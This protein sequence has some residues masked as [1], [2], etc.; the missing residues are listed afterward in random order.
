MD[1]R[2]QAGRA[3]S[4]R[5][6]PALLHRDERCI[7]FGVRRFRLSPGSQ[8]EILETAASAFLTGYNT[9]IRRSAADLA[10][11]LSELGEAQRGHA[12]EGAGMGATVL[13]LLTVGRGRRL[14][15]LLEGP[16]RGHPHL[17]L[18]GAGRGYASLRRRPSRLGRLGRSLPGGH[19]THPALR[20]LAWDGYGCHRGFFRSD[21]TIGGQRLP[22]RLSAEQRALFDQ[23]VGR[24]IW[25]HEC[26]DPDG[27]A[28]RIA[29][30]TPGRRGDLWSG[31]ALAATY[32]GGADVA[33]LGRLASLSGEHRADVAH[34]SALAC[35]ARAHAGLIPAHTAAAAHALTGALAEEA[36][37][38]VATALGRL[39]PAAASPGGYRLWRQEV[40]DLWTGYR[41]H[42]EDQAAELP[43]GASA[44]AGSSTW[45]AG[46]GF[47]AYVPA[48]PGAP[49]QA[50]REPV[51]VPGASAEAAQRRVSV[52]GAPVQAAHQRA[53]VPG[54]PAE[55]ARERVSM[56]GAPAEAARERVSM[57]GAPAEAAHQPVPV[58]GTAHRE[59]HRR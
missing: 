4:G 13:D 19:I 42:G 59:E 24:S 23:G 39:G 50:S 45:D 18:A 30:F 52:P 28:L 25:F 5:G 1:V 17:V 57:P 2:V 7:D 27:V 31:A 20:W 32:T 34:G 38:W 53:R 12:L 11:R 35:A 58:P 43:G 41:S 40:C 48:Q 55:A 9:A 56:P 3:R 8:R 37:G 10:G 36:S 44:E 14:R 54:A 26:A 21:A 47:P 46:A 6:T 51:A 15:A 33:D 49:A 29:E 22:R 16:G